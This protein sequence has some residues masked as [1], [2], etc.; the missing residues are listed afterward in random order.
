MDGA[1][2]VYSLQ[3][4]TSG[5]TVR[6]LQQDTLSEGQRQQLA[7]FRFQQY[8]LWH[9]YD[10]DTIL[11]HQIRT[12][13]A[14]ETLPAE[15]LHALVGTA[16]GRILAYFSMLPALEDQW[17]EDRSGLLS[18]IQRLWSRPQSSALRLQDKERPLFPAEYE[19]FGPDVFSSLPKLAAIPLQEIRELHCLLGNQTAP[20]A[21]TAVAV[22]EA[23][24]TIYRLLVAPSLHL[25]AL[26]GCI[27]F[28][29]RQVLRELGMPI[30]YA[31]F[32]PIL[33]NHLPFY[34]E[35]S[36]NDE[37]KFLPFVV[38]SDDLH[39]HP[40]H[41][42]ALNDLLTM[43]DSQRRR[44]LVEWRRASQQGLRRLEPASFLPKAQ[45]KD[46]RRVWQGDVTDESNHQLGDRAIS[47]AGKREDQGRQST[48]KAVLSSALSSAR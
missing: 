37:G 45:A 39:T 29:A 6:V 38:S 35:R 11:K 18:K 36:M 32:A 14:F 5:L 13:P 48:A 23:V 4:P 17:S 16:D 20:S 30:L 19:S 24:Y 44:A 33:H 47:V 7:E 10:L 42:Q 1:T 31:P 25:K 40:E 43:P 27:D 41:F 8:L 15:T 28:E 21:A 3:R 34:W 12:D 9:W 22:V 26:I 2:P 46:V